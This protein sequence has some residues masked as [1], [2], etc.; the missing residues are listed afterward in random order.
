MA[1]EA[2]SPSHTE[3][4]AARA[5]AIA[6][7]PLPADVV[8]AAKAC[9]LHALV[10]T[11]AAG[12]G[13]EPV[14][15]L[16][17]KSAA[18][19]GHAD[20]LV[21]GG[22]TSAVDAA[23]ANA[24]RSAFRGQN[25]TH[26]ALSGHVGCVVVPATL[27]AAQ[28][29][30]ATGS[31]LLRGLVAGY[32]V[33]V[34]LADGVADAART[35]GLRTTSL[36]GPAG[37]AAAIASMLN[38]DHAATA[39]AIAFGLDAGSGTLQCWSE[40]TSEWLWQASRSA[41]DGVTAAALA[42]AGASAARFALEGRKGFA[43]AHVDARVPTPATGPAW[44]VLDVELKVFPGCYINQTAAT[45]LLDWFKR[46]GISP[47]QITSIEVRLSPA[48]ASY[49]GVARHGPFDGSASAVMS[50]PF[51]L[52][53]VLRDRSIRASHFADEHGF[54]S[55]HDLSH[56]IVVAS[57][58]T[59]P[60]Y[61]A[62]VDVRLASG[63]VET[64]NGVP[65]PRAREGLAVAAETLRPLAHEWQWQDSERRYAELVGAVHDLEKQ[66]VSALTQPCL[67]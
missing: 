54:G 13:A 57:D 63:R 41:A 64:L 37:A 49:P 66:P 28:A 35:R 38:F 67:P 22:R 39:R 47:A 44:H 50:M 11:C 40:G 55:L 3:R 53:A 2:H 61:D 26:P 48:D 30:G 15:D 18:S 45:A 5:Q 65:V 59:I 62:V 6:A 12:S 29:Q 9:L 19:N 25:D 4:L 7:G 52:A 10:V 8:E 34:A 32:E 27:A 33:M 36:L 42:R 20:L 60:S 56:R 23:A 1:H 21:V 58:E 16:F 31:D 51:M 17:A 43:A 46:S 14:R 24:A